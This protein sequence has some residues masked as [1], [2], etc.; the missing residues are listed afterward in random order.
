MDSKEAFFKENYEEI[1]KLVEKRRA[2]WRLTTLA[3]EDVSAI[4][5]ERI[6]TQFHLYDPTKPL[7]R[8]VN[9]LITN[10]LH[11]LL[12]DNLYRVAKPCN[13]AN[14][15][16]APC[17]YNLGCGRCAWTEKNGSGSGM[18]DSSCAFYAKWEKK[19]QAKF[20]IAT[21]LSIENHTDE[22]HS[23][24]SDFLDIDRAKSVIDSKILSHLSSEEAKIYN[25]LFIQHLDEKK[26]G[27]IMGYKK[28]SNSDICGYL[29]IRAATIKIK[30]VARQIISEE[31]LA[32]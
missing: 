18:Q 2:T 8:W 29:Q 9:T 23:I 16:G 28:Q 26:V 27:E 31:G 19:K 6:W 13:A 21:P 22:S 12:R 7:D 10:T 3:W 32:S 14:A 1:K 24:Q 30:K 15:Y 5:I 4:L 17:A 25:L 20:A 11:N